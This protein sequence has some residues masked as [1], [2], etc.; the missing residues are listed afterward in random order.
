MARANDETSTNFCGLF[1]FV[2]VVYILSKAGGFMRAMKQGRKRA[3][4]GALVLSIVGF[5]I[6]PAVL[7]NKAEGQRVEAQGYVLRKL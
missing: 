5:W 2:C 6:G 7:Q 4:G 1:A 3:I